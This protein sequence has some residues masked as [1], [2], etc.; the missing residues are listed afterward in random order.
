MRMFLRTVLFASLLTLLCGASLTAGT[1]GPTC[2]SCFGG[3]YSLNVT[4]LNAVGSYH[5]VYRID[6]RNM[7]LTPDYTYVGSI[8]VKLASDSTY[9]LA[10]SAVTV[11]GTPLGT[12]AY[13]LNTNDTSRGCTGGG[14]GWTCLAYVS[15]AQMAVGHLG[16]GGGIYTWS[17][18]VGG[19]SGMLNTASISANFD[20]PTGKLMSEQV[21]VGAAEG[22]P[23]EL[24]IVLSGIGAFLVWRRYGSETPA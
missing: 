16:V 22:V 6:T 1:I 23:A 4:A 10:N 8:A 13:S 3:I 11:N 9:V 7:N 17:F 24:P 2:G 18:D 20:P 19:V 21:A 5:V 15:G 14:S 12:Y